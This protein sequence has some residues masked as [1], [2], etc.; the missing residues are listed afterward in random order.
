MRKLGPYELQLMLREAYGEVNESVDDPDVK[1]TLDVLIRRMGMNA[2]EILLGLQLQVYT[3]EGRAK[4]HS[5]LE[6]QPRTPPHALLLNWLDHVGP[7]EA[8]DTLRMLT[9]DGS[10]DESVT[11]GLPKLRGRK[12]R[13]VTGDELRNM[14][15]ACGDGHSNEVEDLP[16]M[17]PADSPSELPQGVITKVQ[18]AEPDHDGD[19]MGPD[20]GGRNLGHG[21]KSRMARQQLHQVAEYAVELWNMLDDEDEVPEWCQSKI[22]VM[23]DNIGKVKHHIEYK[24]KKPDVLRLDGE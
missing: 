3:G 11:M 17:L 20:D 6:S 19:G 21:G 23:A 5:W 8:E 2:S 12:Y 1:H 24:V 7:E 22:A 13:K 9:M 4:M 10:M 16:P 18:G 15:E 14:I